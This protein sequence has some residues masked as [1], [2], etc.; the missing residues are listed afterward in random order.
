MKTVKEYL[1][2]LERNKEGRPEQVRDGLEIYIEL[3]RKT[4]L[5]GVIADSDRVEDA[6][7]KIEKAGGLY[8]AAEG[9]T[10]AAPTG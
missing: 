7:E 8:T 10:D 9:P 1:V 3:W 5:R 4:I 6:L 2:E